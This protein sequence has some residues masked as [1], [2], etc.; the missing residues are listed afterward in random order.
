MSFCQSWK[1][2]IRIPKA[3]VSS[4]VATSFISSPINSVFADTGVKVNG[5]VKFSSEEIEKVAPKGENVA[6]YLTAR[7]DVGVWNSA[8]RNVKPPPILSKRITGMTFPYAATLDSDD[9]CTPEGKQ[10]LDQWTNSGKGLIIAARLDS[11]GTAQTRDPADLI[12]QGVAVSTGPRAY[13][14]FD[15]LL[16]GRGVAGKF[17]TNPK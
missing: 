7:E 2:P 8:V 13:G 14:N 3:I 9:D 4:I 5:V 17:I 1:I 15:I 10:I 6:L 16:I 11:D 12:G